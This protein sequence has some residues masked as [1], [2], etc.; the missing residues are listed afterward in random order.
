MTDRVVHS[1][2]FSKQVGSFVRSE[3][4]RNQSKET[5]KQRWRR[6]R[7]FANSNRGQNFDNPCDCCDDL[8]RSRGYFLW[9]TRNCC[10]VVGGIYLEPVVDA[11][12]IE[13]YYQSEA[14]DCLD[15]FSTEWTIDSTGD[16]VTATLRTTLGD[17][18]YELAASTWQPL[19][20]NQ[21]TLQSAPADCPVAPCIR[22]FPST[23]STLIEQPCEETTYCQELPYA[24]T[25][26]LRGDQTATAL[27][28]NDWAWSFPETEIDVYGAIH[29][30][31][32]SWTGTET[33]SCKVVDGGGTEEFCSIEIQAKV[34]YLCQGGTWAMSMAW[35]DGLIYN[36]GSPS[37]QECYWQ[38]LRSFGYTCPVSPPVTYQPNNV[39]AHQVGCENP[40][41]NEVPIAYIEGSS[42]N[43]NGGNCLANCAGFAKI[44]CCSGVTVKYM[45]ACDRV[46][47]LPSDTVYAPV[48]YG[49]AVKAP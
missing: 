36:G 10:D 3:L 9:T 47:S 46:Y 37:S 30:Y 34:E 35:H 19:C 23:C 13:G 17:I 42:T 4:R 20:S 6:H 41:P 11:E 45:N 8:D 38:K 39:Y 43:P 49:T 14:F 15:G 48:V 22:V 12:P 44:E 26:T 29:N 40:F 7:R 2:E 5:R 25:V 27:N 31:G 21:L 24:M 32:V 28:P 1:E 33:V 16:P 18:V